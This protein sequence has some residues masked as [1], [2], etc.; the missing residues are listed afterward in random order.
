MVGSEEEV[1]C[2]LGRPSENIVEEIWEQITPLIS[3]RFLEE[4]ATQLNQLKTEIVQ[5]IDGLDFQRA[6]EEAFTKIVTGIYFLALNK[7]TRIARRIAMNYGHRIEQ[8]SL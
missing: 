4:N 5:E 7:D 3:Q 6:K 8:I 1:N 2:F